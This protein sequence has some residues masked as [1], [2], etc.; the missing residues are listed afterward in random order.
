MRQKT[1]VLEMQ[2]LLDARPVQVVTENLD[3]KRVEE[4]FAERQQAYLSRDR[5][6][7]LLSAA[8]L[9]HQEDPPGMCSCGTSFQSCKVGQL[10]EREGRGL[11]NWESKQRE[12]MERGFDHWLP[13][14]HPYVLDQRGRAAREQQ[15]LR[16]ES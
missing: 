14:D 13:D 10:L 16:G 15:R 12:H 6:Y 2:E 3:L 8:T 7:Q 9:L 11:R 5:A 1:L 4:A